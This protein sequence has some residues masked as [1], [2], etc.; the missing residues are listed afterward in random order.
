MFAQDRPLIFNF[1]AIHPEVLEYFDACML[2]AF[3]H[4]GKNNF[5]MFE[6]IW[7][8]EESI[9]IKRGTMYASMQ[10]HFRDKYRLQSLA[11]SESKLAEM[12]KLLQR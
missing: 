12:E 3:N 1:E 8:I 4:G 5:S 10:R 9:G 6:E 7:F 2:M 11:E